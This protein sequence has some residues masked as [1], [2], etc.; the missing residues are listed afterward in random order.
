MNACLITLAADIADAPFQDSQPLQIERQNILLE[1]FF[2]TIDSAYMNERMGG[3]T[4]RETCEWGGNSHNFAI[5]CIDGIVNSMCFESVYQ[6][7]FSIEFLPTT[8]EQIILR[9]CNQKYQLQTRM[10]PKGMKWLYLT[11]N[12][13]FG[14]ID[15]QNLPRHMRV[16]DV[17]KNNINGPIIL[18]GLPKTICNLCVSQN[19]I[20]QEVLYYD[21]L[22]GSLIWVSLG[23]NR[24][25]SIQPID[26]GETQHNIFYGSKGLWRTE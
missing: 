2:S 20:Q 25:H 3:Q 1:T 21:D 7:N 26:D 9:R 19:D 8:I 16:F 22:P 17:S 5:R 11:N 15:I 12:L 13:L 6:G 14:T 23:G 24:I 4:T 18:R 10:L